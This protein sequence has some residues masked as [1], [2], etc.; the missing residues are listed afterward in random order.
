MIYQGKHSLRAVPWS[1]SLIVLLALTLAL[2]GCGKKNKEVETN[3]E[4]TASG[5]EEGVE[6]VDL[7][8]E[9]FQGKELAGETNEGEDLEAEKEAAHPAVLLQDVFFDYDK[10][11]LSDE[12][13][14]RLN[15]DGRLLREEKGVH[16]LLEGHCDER[17]TVQ[18]NLA[19]GEKRAQEV[20]EYLAN[21]G[22]DPSRFEIVSY[23]KEKP[24]ASGH[25]EEA[26]AQNRRVHF[27]LR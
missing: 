25:T 4:A 13:R 24:F 10:Y 26:W 11:D 16:V 1:V 15:Q 12:A 21:L 19:L 3:P 20:K 8:E 5:Q 9:S 17:G 27:V 22:I 23:G 6:N 18:Y 14:D 7:Q 2:G